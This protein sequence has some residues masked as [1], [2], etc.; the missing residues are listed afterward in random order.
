MGSASGELLRGRQGGQLI[1]VIPALDGAAG[2][3]G[4]DYG[5][6]RCASVH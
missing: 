6:A 1:I 4:G 5:A 2:F 3:T